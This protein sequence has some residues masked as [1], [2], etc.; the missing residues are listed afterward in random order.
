MGRVLTFYR[1]AKKGNQSNE[2]YLGKCEDTALVVLK[3]AQG[4][5]QEG[6]NTTM[7]RRSETPVQ[8]GV[9][10]AIGMGACHAFGSTFFFVLHCDTIR[11]GGALGANGKE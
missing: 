10:G 5:R 9:R 6:E 11:H 2:N 3:R 7:A 8:D 1:N 4:P